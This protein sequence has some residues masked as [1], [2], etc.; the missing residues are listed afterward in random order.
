MKAAFYEGN[1][2]VSLGHCQIEAPGPNQVRLQIAYCG[3]CGTDLHIFHGKMDKRVT[4][5]QIMGHELSAT[6]AEVGAG[7]T[8]VKPGQ[9]VTVMPLDWCGDCP[10]CEAGQYPY[11]P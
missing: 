2:T 3:I 5:P 11:L 7:V 10:A 1:E 6:V 4:F 8:H 9:P